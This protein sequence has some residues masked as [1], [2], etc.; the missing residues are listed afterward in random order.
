MAD[1][2]EQVQS[3]MMELIT[4]SHMPTSCSTSDCSVVPSTSTFVGYSFSPSVP[5]LFMIVR[6]GES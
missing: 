5:A 1:V 3:A 2:P 6:T 4:A